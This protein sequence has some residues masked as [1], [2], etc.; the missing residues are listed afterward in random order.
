MVIALVRSLPIN[1]DNE[2]LCPIS[3]AYEI[4]VDI[5][6]KINKLTIDG[7][8]VIAIFIP[9]EWEKFKTLDRNEIKKAVRFFKW[10]NNA[11]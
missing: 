7:N 2:L 8:S 4:A 3:S 10:R 6:E 11:D 1:T 9:R 5:T